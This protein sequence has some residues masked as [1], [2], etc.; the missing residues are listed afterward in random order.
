MNKKKQQS[1][2]QILPTTKISTVRWSKTNKKNEKEN[3]RKKDGGTMFG[4]RGL[5]KEIDMKKVCIVKN[6]KIWIILYFYFC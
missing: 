3:E 6:Q 2:I 4:E 1:S 5:K